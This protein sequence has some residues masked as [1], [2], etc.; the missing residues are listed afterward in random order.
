MTARRPL[1]GL[2][3]VRGLARLLLGAERRHLGRLASPIAQ[4]HLQPLLPK[5]ARVVFWTGETQDRIDRFIDHDA[6]VFDCMD[7]AFADADDH[8]RRQ[9]RVLHDADHVV[10][11]ADLL[12]EECRRDHANVTLLKNAAAT[13]ED[14][15]EPFGEAVP[16]WWPSGGRPI[17]AY[18]GSIDWRFDFDLVTAVVAA[19]PALDFVIAGNLP[20]L[21]APA[22]ADLQSVPNVAMPGR[23]SLAHGRFLVNEASACLIPFRVEA[24]NDAVNPVKPYMY[25]LAGKPIIGTPIRELRQLGDLVM[26][27][28][29][30][31]SFSAALAKAQTQNGVSVGRLQQFGRDNTWRHRAE[32]AMEVIRTL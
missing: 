18:L 17:C 12:Y 4:Y 29:D 3:V 14:P 32:L 28:G 6:L 26:L 1:P 21:F 11:S 8:R 7:P 9:R 22:A 30:V 10:A 23:I 16:A 27:A 31:P 20:E 13:D 24:H 15:P 25:A 5:G 2:T 19:N